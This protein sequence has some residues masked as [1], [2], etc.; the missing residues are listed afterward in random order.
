MAEMKGTSADIH[1]EDYMAEYE[2]SF[3][4]ADSMMYDRFRKKELL[5]GDW[6]YAVDQYDT[7]IRQHWYR[8]V[9]EI[10][11][12][13]LPVDYS[14]DEWPVMRLPASWNTVEER[15]LLYE[16]SMVF[17]RRFRYA[18]ETEGEKVFLKIGAANYLCRVFLNRQYVG[19]HR[20]GSTPF[21]FDITKYL[22]KENRIIIQV[23]ASRRPTQVPTENTDWFNYGGVFRDIALIRLPGVFVKSFRV[24]LIPDGHFDRISLGAELSA[25]TDMTARFMIPEL[26]ID[27]EVEF[28]SGRAETFFSASPELWSP[29]NPKLYDVCLSLD[30]GDAVRDR[31][32]FREIRAEGRRILLNGK[33]IFLRGISMHEDSVETGRALTDSERMEKISIAKELGCN[34][35]RL[36]HY[37]HSE[38]MA[39]L[40]DEMG[41]LLWEEIPVYWAIRFT[42]DKTYADARN[43]LLE[44]IRRDYNRAS[45]IIWSVGNENPDSDERFRFMKGL[46]DTARAED[47]TRMVSAACLVS[48][49][50]NAIADRLAEVLDVIGL[51]EYVGWYSPDF[52][53]LPQLFANSS[54]VKP[55]I[56]TECG[57]DALAGHHGT[58][59]DKGTEEYQA[60][61]YRKQVEVISG[62]DYV[63][64]MTPWIL[65]DFRCPRRT[66]F[67]QR[68]Y[69]TK[70][71]LSADRKHRKLAFYVLQEFYRSIA[72]GKEKS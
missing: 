15:Y 46:A 63:R 61:V 55:V 1:V 57:A 5:N 53:R 38:R 70:G 65:F 34:F 27:E 16:Q 62:I 7:C 18:E 21:F 10:G 72:G 32:G 54:P 58:D 44:L 17:T 30:G 56:I 68:Y 47:G 8:E 49:E 9:S 42:N 28:L 37:P 20:G 12:F 43:Q 14:F 23:D 51:H 24:S 52:A 26:G 40:A 50:K 67:L 25:E 6:H 4:D 3:T 41:L 64:G 35:M 71:L 39:E 2:S 19:M 22:E 45:V 59:S 60:E 33:D 66:S 11:G 69:N 13:T 29:E 31:V 36:A 48:E